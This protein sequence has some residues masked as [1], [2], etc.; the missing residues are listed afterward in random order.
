MEDPYLPLPGEI[1]I[2]NYG[3]R[4]ISAA[5]WTR[6]ARDTTTGE[7]IWQGKNY[8]YRTPMNR[9]RTFL[10]IRNYPWLASVKGKV[11]ALQNQ[12]KSES[13]VNQTNMD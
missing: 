4:H 10:E 1:K 7:I 13:D 8:R 12:L 11:N 9:F 6:R 5:S 2:P 3:N